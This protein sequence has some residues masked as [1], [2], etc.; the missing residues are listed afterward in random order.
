MHD[1]AGVR[2]DIKDSIYL[3]WVGE[4]SMMANELGDSG[5]VR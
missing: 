1:I 3:L 4:K 5:M 2:Q